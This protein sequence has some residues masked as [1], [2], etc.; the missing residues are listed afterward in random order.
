MKTIINTTLRELQ[1]IEFG[2]VA[3]A[4]SRSMR[5]KLD[6]LDW[7]Q[8][9][10]LRRSSRLPPRLKI[11]SQSLIDRTPSNHPQVHHASAF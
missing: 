7:R 4:V 3:R 9:A 8:I 2:E 5:D 6:W 10:A 1:D 11:P